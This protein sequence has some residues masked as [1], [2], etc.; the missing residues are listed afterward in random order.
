ELNPQGAYHLR[1]C[2]AGRW[3]DLVVDDLF[4][5]SQVSEGF[6]DGRSIHFSR[7]GNLCYLGGARRQLWP[8][9]VEKAAAKLFGS[10]G[11]LKGGTFIEALALFTGFPTQR[12]RLYEPKADRL[13]KAERQ[14]ARRARRMQLLLSGADVPP[15]ES[16]DSDDD[17]MI[18]SKLL[19]C[20]DAGYLMGMGCSEEGCEKSKQHIVE[21]MGLQAPHAYGILDVREVPVNSSTVRLVKIRNPWGQ[22]APRTWKGKWG[23]DSDAWTPELQKELGVINSSGVLMD[24]PMSIF[25]M[26]FEDV[27]EYFSQVEICRVHLGW[28]EVRGVAWLA[29]ALGPGQAFDL[30]VQYRTNVDIA[31]WQERHITREGALG[32]RCTNI[33]VGLAVMRARGSGDDGFVQYELIDYSTRSFDDGVSVEVILEGG[34]VYR[35]V[36]LCMGLLLSSEP[37]QVTLAVHSVQPVELRKVDSSWREVASAACNGTQK[38]GKRWSHHRYPDL[39]YWHQFEPGGCIFMVENRSSRSVA[40]QAD[41]SDSAGCIS[42]RGDF[43]VVAR[44]PPQR[45]R[46]ILALAFSPGCAR[47]SASIQPQLVPLEMGPSE[48]ASDSSSVHMCLPLVPTGWRDGSI[49]LPLQFQALHSGSATSNSGSSPLPA[50]TISRGPVPAPLPSPAGRDLEVPEQRATMFTEDDDELA[51]AIRLSLA[52][53]GGSGRMAK[54]IPSSGLSWCG[55]SP[56]NLEEKARLEKRTKELFATF[57]HQGMAPNEAAARASDEASRGNTGAG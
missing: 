36:P 38:R 3:V 22:I 25:W 29:S 33:D 53:Q 45:R 54:A 30:T 9:L 51:E 34:Y 23:K 24:D 15:D 32:A 47:A 19:S 35:L 55:S 2:H 7:G 16:D 49:P 21:E 42:S 43:G 27:K 44:V 14:Q 28:N 13:D 12:L 31:V 39:T 8:P 10:Y 4:P 17:D 48:D 1:L 40:V 57:R 52:S 5:T 37:R 11:A 6:S 50:P 41:A 26:A 20:K 46:I 56:R 18:W